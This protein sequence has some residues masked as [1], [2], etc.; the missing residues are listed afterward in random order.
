MKG[1]FLREIILSTITLTWMMKWME[2]GRGEKSDTE[3]DKG[4]LADIHAGDS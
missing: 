3:G 1:S 4:G 2:V